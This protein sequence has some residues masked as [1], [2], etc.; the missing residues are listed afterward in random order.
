MSRKPKASDVEVDA[1]IMKFMENNGRLPTIA[2]IRESLPVGIG[3]DRASMARRRAEARMQR[4]GD[5]AT[6]GGCDVANGLCLDQETGAGSI[7]MTM[8]MVRQLLDDLDAEC[9]RREIALRNAI[10]ARF[11][12]EAHQMLDEVLDKFVE[13]RR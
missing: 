10:N 5:E 12:A 6:D 11:R 8:G 9:A 1:A 2:E 4:E 7:P 3:N 13:R